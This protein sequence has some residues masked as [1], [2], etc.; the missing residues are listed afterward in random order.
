MSR[1][2]RASNRW[3]ALL[4]TVVCGCAGANVDVVA[5]KALYPISMSGSVRDNTGTLHDA[6]SLKIVG[7][8][9]LE[10]SRVGFLYSTATVRGKL[11]ISEAINAQVQ[12][13]GG[14][15]VIRLSIT[16]DDS[17]HWVNELFPL[18]ALPIW[19]GCVP[20]KIHGAIVRRKIVAPPF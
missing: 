6:R 20:V 8:F 11:D 9:D 4:A 19:P 16:V 18:N 5:D 2:W 10:E 15:A 17:C 14:E 12:A 13:V 1:P 7:A 3:C